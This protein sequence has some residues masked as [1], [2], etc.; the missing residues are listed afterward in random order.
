MKPVGL[1][2]GRGISLVNDLSQVNYSEPIVVQVRFVCLFCVCVH[3]CV[4]ECMCVLTII[5]L[6]VCVAV[7]CSSAINLMCSA[8]LHHEPDASRWLQI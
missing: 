5:F 3:V 4:C 8:A 2:R 1:S 7:L 6:S